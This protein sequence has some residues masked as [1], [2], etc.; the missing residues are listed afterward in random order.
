MAL[1]ITTEKNTLTFKV[2]D[3]ARLLQVT[4]TDRDRLLQE[5]DTAVSERRAADE[6]QTLAER[7]I[8]RLHNRI[9]ALV[10]QVKDRE[11]VSRQSKASKRGY[12]IVW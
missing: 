10:Q 8:E 9:D 2:R 6:G 11:E 3:L 12:I 7:E 1:D 5:C 4:E